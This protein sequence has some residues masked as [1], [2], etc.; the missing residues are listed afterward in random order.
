MTDQVTRAAVLRRLELDVAR[1]LDGRL[2]GDYRTPAYGPGSERAG[3]RE[4]EPGDDARRIDWNLTARA[5]SPFVRTTEAD[6]EL[7]TWVVVDRSA[8]LDFG[9]ADRE[10]R[11]AVLG[12]AAAYGV[13]TA[14]SGNRLGVLVCGGSELVRRPAASG[15]RAM[16]A[17]LATIHDAPRRDAPPGPDADLTAALVAL[18]RLQPRRGLVVVVSDF[19][20]AS[21][22]PAGLRSLCLRQHVVAVH[23]CD[24]RELELPDVGMLGV[25]DPE[26]GRLLH[27]QTRSVRLARA[28]RRSRPARQ[29]AIRAAV[30]HAGAE[31]LSVTTDRDWL[32]DVIGH[33]TARRRPGRAVPVRRPLP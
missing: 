20:D 16:L 3:A 2:S 14:R 7:E 9:T 31:Y 15:R 21:D 8:S 1:R 28:V 10:K 23:V 5:H 19:L 32:T 29:D 6:R 4:Y 26:T 22:W 11:D 24:P 13:L 18:P 12:V 25:V 30:R 27:V 33:V 17:A